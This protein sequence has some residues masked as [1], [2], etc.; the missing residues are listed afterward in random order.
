MVPRGPLF[1][2]GEISVI[3]KFFAIEAKIIVSA[4]VSPVEHAVVVKG[5]LLHQKIMK[6]RPILYTMN[7]CDTILSQKALL[8]RCL[9]C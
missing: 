8:T 6:I 2:Q 9:E 7:H 3:G 5:R 4:L 1:T